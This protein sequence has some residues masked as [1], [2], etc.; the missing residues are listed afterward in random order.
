MGRRLKKKDPV[1]MA[2]LLRRLFHQVDVNGDGTMEW[3][4]F[5]S[6]MIEAAR[7]KFPR[8]T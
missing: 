8:N 3:D 4:E 5:T 6:Y 7:R 1:R 2:H